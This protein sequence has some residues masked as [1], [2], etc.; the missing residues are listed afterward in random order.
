MVYSIASIWFGLYDKMQRKAVNDEDVS[1]EASLACV[2][3]MQ[4][5]RNSFMQF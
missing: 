5:R 1:Y 2:Y 4:F 3:K